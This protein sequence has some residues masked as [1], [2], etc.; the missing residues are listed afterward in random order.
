MSIREAFDHFLTAPDIPQCL[1][2]YDQLKQLCGPDY[3]SIKQQCLSVIPYRQKQLFAQLDKKYPK[4]NLDSR[5]VVSG[6]G[7]CGLRAAFEARSLGHHVVLIE[8]RS[9]CSRHNILKTWPGTV[10]DLKDMGLMTFIPTFKPH[11]H[12]HLGTREIQL[13][14]IK[15]CLLFGVEV[16]FG[17]GVCGLYFDNGW[18]VWTLPYD[19]ATHFLKKPEQRAELA[20]QPGEQNADRLESVS[21]VDFFERAESMDGGIYKSIPEKDYNLYPFES[22]IVAEGESSRLVRKLGFDRKVQRYNGAIGIVVNLLFS[23]N[24][25][26]GSPELKIEEFVRTRAAADWQ[27][28]PLGQLFDQGIELE[29]IEYMRGTDTH[30]IACTSKIQ[31]LVNCKILK[32]MRSTTKEC[33]DSENVDFDRLRTWM[34]Q[35][36]AKACGIPPE[37]PLAKKNGIQIF[38]FSCKGLVTP[39][40][41]YLEQDGKRGL[42]L[43]CGDTFQNPY[44]PQGLGVNRGIHNSLDACWAAHLNKIQPEIVEEE[45]NYAFKVMDWT[46][47]HPGCVTEKGWEA[48]PM[49]RYSLHITKSIVMNEL[50][51]GRDNNVLPRFRSAAYPD[52]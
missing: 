43:P 30:F 49:T 10:Q 41:R 44:W 21:K 35:Q 19:Q 51:T 6:A 25:K 48:D 50:E 1:E 5:I 24:V 23:P 16:H 52:N 18:H 8:L 27:K 4:Q 31:H 47:F 26:P 28:G 46:A 9:Y 3:P 34:A 14:L 38:D 45:R 37:C 12:L 20:I 11:G 29:N 40:M 32:Q 39:L 7:P 2:S 33:L 13:V 17:E 22:L 36:L 15:N 42:I